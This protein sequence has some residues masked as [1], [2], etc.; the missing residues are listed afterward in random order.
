MIKSRD[1]ENLRN[2]LQAD[3]YEGSFFDFFGSR[4]KS[5]QFS[6]DEKIKN[7]LPKKFCPVI[8]VVGF[9]R[10]RIVGDNC[11]ACGRKPSFSRLLHM[12]LS[13]QGILL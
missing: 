3:L 2:F 5:G 10:E 9:S 1:L 4:I 13:S 7:F 8:S 12:P 6:L 11:G